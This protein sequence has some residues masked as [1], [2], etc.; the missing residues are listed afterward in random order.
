MISVGCDNN[1][2]VVLFLKTKEALKRNV[3]F[4]L[5][6]LDLFPTCKCILHVSSPF[7]LQHDTSACLSFISIQKVSLENHVQEQ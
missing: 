1:Y 5:Q 7:N 2:S 4:I 6:L 3:A